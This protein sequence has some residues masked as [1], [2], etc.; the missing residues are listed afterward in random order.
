MKLTGNRSRRTAALAIAVAALS[1]LAAFD[2]TLGAEP[3]KIGFSMALT[4]AYA[5]NGKA[6]LVAT[7][8]WAEDQNSPLD[9]G[10]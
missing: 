7:Q 2:E 10:W 5:G 6:A 4:G 1:L 8:M 9:L 3:I